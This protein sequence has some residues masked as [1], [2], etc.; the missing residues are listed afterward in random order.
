MTE[1]PLQTP[2]AE[3]VDPDQVLAEYPRPIMVRPDWM[4]LNGLWQFKEAVAG[5]KLP[6]G[7][8]LEEHIL[9][10]FPWESA[11]SGVRKQ[12][13]SYRAI[14]RRT[15]DLPENW[16]AER[17]LLHFGAVDWEA[18]IY[19]NGRCVGIH[20]GGYD[21]FS[22]DITAF[23]EEGQQ[24]V[25][26]AVYDP[27]TAEGITVGKQNNDRFSD[28]QRYAYA[29]ASGIWQTVWLEP[30]PEKYIADLKII[31]D[32]DREAV[33][34]TV[35]A[36]TQ[37][38]NELR[39]SVK[40]LDGT[41]TVGTAT[42][43]FHTPIRLPIPD[44]TLWTPDTPFLY[45]LEISVVDS[46]RT[47]DQVRS[48]VGMRKISM[49]PYKGIQR[50]MLNDE[51]VFQMGPLDQGYWP[52]GLYTAPT[53]AALRWDVAQIKAFGYN[54]VR[55]HIKVEPQRWYYWCDKL[56]LLV[57]QDMPSTF[58]KRT[59]V[60][61]TVFEQELLRMVKSHWNHPSIINWIVFN[62]HW[63]AYDVE[64]LTEMVMALDPSRLV[65][66]NSGI[67]AGRPDVD[68]AVGHIKDNHSYR[69]PSVPFG[70]TQR[71]VVNGEYGAIG[72]LAD[73]HVWDT[74]G[75]W[76]HY[77]YADKAA[78]TAEY[79]RFIEM[80]YGFQEEG[81]SAAVYTQWT[82]L[83]NE[84]NGIYTYDRKVIKLEREQVTNAN[85]STYAQ[86]RLKAKYPE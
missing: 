62:E 32:I 46:T 77:N 15:F 20:Q 14:Y 42:G 18:T 85:R 24:E 21:A 79:I 57:W 61:K 70:N 4:N 55:K 9:V 78:A 76:V 54:M 68:Y 1:V 22:F 66:G 64:R 28:P 56:G 52:D 26:V 6:F 13:D 51:F 5:E 17:I 38:T 47:L 27:G 16:S 11:L 74:D 30:V 44:P 73:G 7:T 3:E 84:M 31:P 48:Y 69:P 10:P 36:S 72:Y 58:K 80:I 35:N 12:F 40:A 50:L 75:P 67:D 29:P 53:D 34:V 45:D 33:M 60:E 83:E 19:V 71:A 37:R 41:S 39:V 86:D 25:I 8:E 43:K 63:G 49:S 2:W 59:E 65:T 23:L 82:D 81:L